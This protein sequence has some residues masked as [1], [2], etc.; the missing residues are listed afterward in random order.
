M[1]R[2]DHLDLD[3]HLL[4]LLLVVPEEGSITRA[5]QWLDVTQS[6]VSDHMNKLRDRLRP[7]FVKPG[8]AASCR[9]RMQL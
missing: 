5:A 7:L 4:Q 6:T 1:S 2:F 9:P 3:G 8:D